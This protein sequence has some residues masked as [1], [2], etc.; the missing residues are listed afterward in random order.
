MSA[1]VVS[2]VASCGPHSGTMVLTSFLGFGQWSTG[3]FWQEN[4][5][6]WL[7]SCCL[8]RSQLR[9]WLRRAQLFE[10][11]TELVLGFG[12]QSVDPGEGALSLESTSRASHPCLRGMLL[13]KL[14]T[15][16]LAPHLCKGSSIPAVYPCSS[17]TFWGCGL[18]VCFLMGTVSFCLLHDF[19]SD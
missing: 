18:G 9:I 16:R 2:W 7:S 12:A 11:L 1:E 15:L 5:R 13:G 10:L 19:F 4:W 17:E 6:F 8:S 3:P 14:P